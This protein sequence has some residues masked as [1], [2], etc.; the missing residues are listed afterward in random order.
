ME[1]PQPRAHRVRSVET[2]GQILVVCTGNVCRSPFIERLLQS[3]LALRSAGDGPVVRS[4]GTGALVGQPMDDRAAA[5]LRAAGGS[6]EGFL[7]RELTKEMVAE[8]DLV[9]TATRGHRGRVATLH[10]PSLRYA[11]TFRDFAGLAEEVDLAGLPAAPEDPRGR[12]RALVAAVAARRGVNPPL[13]PR[14]A[15]IVDPYRREDQVFTQMSE[16]VLGAMPSVLTALV[17]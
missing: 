17:G 6:A 10:P 9:L 14:Q 11:F 2:V 8:A 4:A 13:S 5:Q 7:A 16:Q 3:E 15:D 12:L 1:Q